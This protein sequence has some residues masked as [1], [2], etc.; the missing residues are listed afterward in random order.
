MS[1]F[2]VICNWRNVLQSPLCLVC[3][4]AA[5]FGGLTPSLFCELFTPV[6]ALL[7]D[8]TQR[9]GESTPTSDSHTPQCGVLPTSASLCRSSSLP[10]TPGP[11]NQTTG[12]AAVTFPAPES[13]GPRDACAP[14]ICLRS[15]AVLLGGP[16]PLLPAMPHPGVQP[17]PVLREVSDRSLATFKKLVGQLESP[18]TSFVWIASVALVLGAGQKAVEWPLAQ[19]LTLTSTGAPGREGGLSLGALPLSFGS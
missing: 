9:P 12:A 8:C 10:P 2:V 19:A 15:A 4:G 18:V 1:G 5:R 7:L 11:L 14:L 3:K 17:C 6:P 13:H 16:S